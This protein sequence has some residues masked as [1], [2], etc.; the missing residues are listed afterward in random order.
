MIEDNGEKQ[1][2]STG[3]S[4]S[5][6]KGRGLPSLLPFDALMELAIHFEEG[7]IVHAP[8]NWE[9]GL[10]LSWY[11]DSLFRH[12]TDIMMGKTNESHHRAF[13]WNAV[14]FLATWVRIQRGEL[15]AE[16]DDLPHH[17]AS[18]IVP[19]E[20]LPPMMTACTTKDLWERVMGRMQDEGRTT[21]DGKDNPP[22]EYEDDE[23]CIL[24]D[25]RRLNGFFTDPCVPQEYKDQ[26]KHAFSTK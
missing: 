16:L 17:I 26:I 5:G 12:L 14:C 13:A 19:V 21:P 4:R 7:S 1:T 2:A 3:A 20:K 25:S 24:M 6:G 23:K 8:R 15:P 22:L 10:P 18:G 9:K 11:I